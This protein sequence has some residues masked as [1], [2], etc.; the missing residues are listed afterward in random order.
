M[1]KY[2]YIYAKYTVRNQMNCFISEFS[3]IFKTNLEKNSYVL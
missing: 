3:S 1:Y 2:I